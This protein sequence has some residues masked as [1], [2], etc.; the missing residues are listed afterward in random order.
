MLKMEIQEDAASMKK[1]KFQI[2]HSAEAADREYRML[3][4]KGDLHPYHVAIALR[5]TENY[6]GSRR[7][8][9]MDAH[10]ASV[11]NTLA[12]RD[13]G[14]HSI[15][16]VKGNTADYCMKEFK[17]FK[18]SKTTAIGDS[19]FRIT[20]LELRSGGKS[21]FAAVATMRE[22]RKVSTIISSVGNTQDVPVI[23]TRKRSIFVANDEGLLEQQPS[24]SDEL[25]IPSMVSQYYKHAHSVDLHNQLR[26]G[27]LNI[28][29]LWKTEKWRTRVFASILGVILVDAY[30]AFSYE[31]KQYPG[32]LDFAKKISLVLCPI[33]TPDSEE[34]KQP[35]NIV[36]VAITH[37]APIELQ[38]LS[39]Y[40]G[41]EFL[42]KKEEK[43]KIDWRRYCTICGDRTYYFCKGCSNFN[44]KEKPIIVPMHGPESNIK[45][46]TKHL[47]I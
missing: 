20:E 46:Y 29:R 16:M 25:Y 12:L 40:V 33:I 19:Q 22:K 10:F 39:D 42:P 43:R 17:E 41:E 34:P 4:K 15:G 13:H 8:I 36:P 38:K 3:E 1:K 18:E 14:L 21:T 7:V 2:R 5:L 28:E 35:I 9:Y 44:D 6:F 31:T 27:I 24:N 23:P 26:Q 11:A 32:I 30:H 47:N 45:C 37:H